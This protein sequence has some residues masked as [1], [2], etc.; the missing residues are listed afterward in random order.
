M[1]CYAGL[2]TVYLNLGGGGGG[3]G[4]ISGVYRGQCKCIKCTLPKV[5]GIVILALAAQ[6]ASLS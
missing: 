6:S 4:G 1:P 3:E 5:C 2:L